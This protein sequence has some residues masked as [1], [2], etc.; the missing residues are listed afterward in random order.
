MSFQSIPDDLIV[1]ILEYDGRIRYKD[2]KYINIIHKK[3]KRYEIIK[4]LIDKK[5][6][7]L[8]NI[9]IDNNGF[10]FEFHFDICDQVGLCYD[11]NYSY[12][13]ILEICYYDT[14]NNDWFQIR[15]FL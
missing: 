5:K 8:N 1:K 9:E 14:R 2:G 11:Y 13:N 12:E 4:P 6:M 10:Y 3:D 15:S 7:I